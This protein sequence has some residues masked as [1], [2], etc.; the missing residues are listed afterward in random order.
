[1]T[2]R[3]HVHGTLFVAGYAE[4]YSWQSIVR[5]G[6]WVMFRMSDK[7]SKVSSLCGHIKDKKKLRYLPNYTQTSLAAIISHG[8]LPIGLYSR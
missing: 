1:M 6:A 4:S 8:K 5:V 2:H 3:C 7:V